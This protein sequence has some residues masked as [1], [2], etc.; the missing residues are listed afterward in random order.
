MRRDANAIVE[1]GGLDVGSGGA[2]VD[3]DAL[4]LEGILHVLDGDIHAETLIP[5]LDRNNTSLFFYKFVDI[6]GGL[7]RP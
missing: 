6:L 2:L 3:D 7:Q 4:T 1:F 5:N